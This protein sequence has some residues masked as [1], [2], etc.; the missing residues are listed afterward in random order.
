VETEEEDTFPKKAKKKTKKN[1]KDSRIDILAIRKNEKKP[2][3]SDSSK[4]G[5]QKINS[6]R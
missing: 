4:E 6:G 3:K 2:P 5:D 1:A